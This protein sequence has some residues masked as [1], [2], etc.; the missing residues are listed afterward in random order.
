MSLAIYAE[1]STSVAIGTSA[2]DS[3]IV[4]HNRRTTYPT[5]KKIYLRNDSTSHWYSNISIQ[6]TSAGIS[7][8]GNDGFGLKFYKGE[9]EPSEKQWERI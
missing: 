3:L 1:E 9:L 4:G 5:I 2:A 8:D 7:V 6:A